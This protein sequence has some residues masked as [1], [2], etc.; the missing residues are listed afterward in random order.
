MPDLRDLIDYIKDGNE[1]AVAAARA[2]TEISERYLWVG[3]SHA[4]LDVLAFI[5][6]EMSVTTPEGTK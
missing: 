1:Q 5:E 3:K 2:S 6:N 4:Y